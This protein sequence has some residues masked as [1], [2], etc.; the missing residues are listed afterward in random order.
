MKGQRSSNGFI[1]FKYL[2][3][4]ISILIF[5]WA[6]IFAASGD[7]HAE[8][9]IGGEMYYECVGGNTYEVTMKLYRDCNSGGAAFDNP[10]TFGVFNASGGLV[11]QVQSFIGTIQNIDPN[12]N[13][14]C[15]DV[16]PDVCVQ[17]GIYTFTV[18]LPNNSQAYQVVYTRCCRNQTI[19]NLNNP[20]SQGLTLVVEIPAASLA[21]CNT[22]PRFNSFPPPVL[23]SFEHFEFDH[24]ATDPDGDSLA[25]SLCSPFIGGTQLNPQPVP[26]PAPPYNEVNWQPPYSAT[27]PLPGNPG[28]TI[29]PI[30]GLLSGN[31]TTMGQYV[32]GVCVEE[33]SNG[34]LIGTH[35]RDFQFNVA[36]CEQIS[37]ADIA[38]LE[39][40]QFCD[41]LTFHFTN[42]SDPSNDFLWDFGDP[43]TTNDVAT[44]FHGNYTYPDT[45]T[46]VVTLITNPGFFC[47]DTT[48]LVVPV[49]FEIQVVIESLDFVCVDGLPLYT[50]TAAGD[51]DASIS[52]ITWDF[53]DNA[54]PP[55]GTGEMVDGISFTQ[56]GTQTVEVN[57]E[58]EIC[59]GHGIVNFNV[60]TPIEITLSE[61]DVFCDGMTYSFHQ[62]S[63]NASVFHWDFGVDG[64]DGDVSE[65]A[66]PTFTFP[67]PGQ[68]EVTVTG[69]STDNCPVSAQSTFNI[70]PILAPQIA[71]LSV[72]CFEG[73]SIDF[74]AAGNYVD[75]ATFSWNFEGGSPAT[76]TAEN[77]TGIHFDTMGNKHITLNVTAPGCSREVTAIQIIHPNPVAEFAP[78]STD[79][80]APARIG[81]VNH[82]TTE[83]VNAAYHWD[84]GDG[85]TAFTRNAN[86]VYEAPGTYTVS[87]HLENL[88]GCIDE[89]EMTLVDV[90]SVHPSPKAGFTIDPKVVSAMDPE[91]SVTAT[92][93]G[94][95]HVSYFFDGEQIDGADFV[96]V[97]N[98]VGPQT[99]FQTVSNEFGCRDYAQADVRISDHLIYVPSAFTPNGD[100]LN[101]LFRPETT[102]IIR[103]DM[104]IFDRWGRRVFHSNDPRGWDGSSNN[105]DYYAPPGVYNYI[106]VITDY[107]KWNFEYT[108]SVRLIR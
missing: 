11:F 4:N 101:D 106:I 53:G 15:L 14:P 65:L 89:D 19:L 58:N 96:H 8:H 72:A 24:S 40:E 75:G 23:C 73:N 57:V 3:I 86:H 42:N 61:Q 38:P 94:Y 87:L 83:S 71:P 107:S 100:G 76:A 28:L 70:Q 25:Y 84:F 6:A 29:D 43:T 104:Q 54:T 80:C 16:P 1:R 47:S 67:E 105:D 59:P 32:V 74:A 50:F 2:R 35:K 63:T 39:N 60:P 78:S 64:S 90:V 52:T 102:G 49:Y 21:T 51:F 85:S 22:S 79:G 88:D 10:A 77:P 82:S 46:Y 9:I 7:M 20:G 41:G 34:Q 26:P 17:E 68:Y 103:I 44:T 92:G 55:T 99:I 45:G 56:P 97:I 18:T 27:N 69:S 37:S 33:W 95:S 12:F 93:E 5:T 13:S 36:Q 98:A 30:T 48:T 81:F 31:P 62:T 108:G 91:V 66:N